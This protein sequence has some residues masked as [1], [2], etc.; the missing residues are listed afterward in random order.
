MHDLN[1]RA[2]IHLKIYI[3]VGERW[4]NT[5]LRSMCIRYDVEIIIFFRSAAIQ[6]GHPI[7]LCS[8]VYEIKFAFEPT[9]N[10]NANQK[11]MHLMQKKNYCGAKNEFRIISSC[12]DK[13][14]KYIY[15]MKDSIFY[16]QYLCFFSLDLIP[17]F[18]F[19]HPVNQFPKKKQWS[20]KLSIYMR[21]SI[22]MTKLFNSLSKLAFTLVLCIFFEVSICGVSDSPV[23]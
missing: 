7:A 11:R 14:T 8:L 19:C 20:I 2:S 17:V 5:V 10:I 6:I 4:C 3:V 22:K 12:N 13:W 15:Y 18:I 1:S 21:F 9:I 16:G 23:W